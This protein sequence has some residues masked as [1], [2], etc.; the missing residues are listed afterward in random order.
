MV[1]KLESF[2][3]SAACLNRKGYADRGAALTRRLTALRP[4]TIDSDALDLVCV[5]LHP[6]ALP[7]NTNLLALDLPLEL[8]MSKPLPPQISTSGL[9]SPED[10]G[11][12][13]DGDVAEL[14]FHPPLP[15]RFRLDLRLA[16][17]GPNAGSPAQ[18]D[19]GDSIHVI[20]IGV[21]P[22]NVT[23]LVEAREPVAR[24]AI[25]VP[26]AISPRSLGVNSDSRRLGFAIRQLEV[27]AVQ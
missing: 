23:L 6:A 20:R 5:L 21:D 10:W 3:F 25:R 18:I 19:V 17:F 15:A 11:R 14:R 12:W 16:A 24:I 9:S 4:E 1:A 27:H 13:T 22:E 8:T 2:G 26:H 7:E